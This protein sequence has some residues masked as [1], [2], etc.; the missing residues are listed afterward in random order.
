MTSLP[1]GIDSLLGKH[2]TFPLEACTPRLIGS[3]RTIT[4]LRVSADLA[5][6]LWPKIACGVISAVTAGT[7]IYVRSAW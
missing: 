3:Y 2:T 5:R 4:R 1:N 6:A 7:L